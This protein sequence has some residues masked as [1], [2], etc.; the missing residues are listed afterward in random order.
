SIKEGLKKP[1]PLDPSGGIDYPQAEEGDTWRFTA[2]GKVGDIDVETGDMLVAKGDSN[3]GNE[4]TAG[5]DFFILQANIDQATEEVHGFA[6]VAKEEDLGTND[7]K[8]FITPKKLEKRVDD[9]G[10]G[11]TTEVVSGQIVVKDGGVDEEKLSQDVKD[12]INEGGGDI[13][14][15]N[16]LYNYDFSQGLGGWH[17]GTTGSSI[18]INNGNLKFVADSPS[19][20]FRAEIELKNNW[21]VEEN[22][23]YLLIIRYRSNSEIR[24]RTLVGLM[25]EDSAS[26]ILDRNDTQEFK[27][28]ALKLTVQDY[29][30]ALLRLYVYKSSGTEV[31][32]W[33]ELN[34]VAIQRG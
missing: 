6:K 4:A 11:S 2:N 5:S 7:D 33:F 25:V 17:R 24:L 19:D 26:Y 20:S 22:G 12:K 15:K 34:Y 18:S 3:G 31:G 23:D 32:D 28:V 27:T 21:D 29:N 13:G 10:D 1:Q 30:T 16:Y 9:L 8:K 14:N